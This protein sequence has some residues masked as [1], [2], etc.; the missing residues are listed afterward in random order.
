MSI[1]EMQGRT[2]VVTGAAGGIGSAIAR[3][4]AAHGASVVAAD[5]SDATAS[6]VGLRDTGGIGIP[7]VCDVSDPESVQAMVDSAI[8]EFG[9]VDVLVNVAGIGDGHPAHELDP[10]LWNRILAVNL[11][12]PFLCVRAA[13]PHL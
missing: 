8:S 4:L 13:M 2:V 9:G 12:G 3:T 6:V 1:T 11:T 10:A 5:I 7:V